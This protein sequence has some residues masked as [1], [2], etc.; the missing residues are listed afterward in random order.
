MYVFGGTD[1]TLGPIVDPETV[2]LLGLNAQYEC[3]L[4]V[5]KFDNL[6]LL[7]QERGPRTIIF[8]YAKAPEN[9]AEAV[10]VRLNGVD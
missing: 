6:T 10:M 3:E 8:L 1:E 4:A 5:M 7:G 2:R 9:N